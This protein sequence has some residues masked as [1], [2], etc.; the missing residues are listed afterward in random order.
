MA[1]P[2]NGSFPGI[3]RLSREIPG[4]IVN[5]TIPAFGAFIHTI[6]LTLIPILHPLP[7]KGEELCLCVLIYVY[8]ISEGSTFPPEIPFKCQQIQMLP[9]VSNF[10]IPKDTLLSQEKD[11]TTKKHIFSLP[12]GLN[13]AYSREFPVPGFPANSTN[14]DQLG[15]ASGSG[16]D[17]GWP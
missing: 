13:K 15:T 16:L 9:T 2:G 5:P 11:V 7:A 17:S 8:F 12:V 14:R 6:T 10:E 4:K 1:F 3:F